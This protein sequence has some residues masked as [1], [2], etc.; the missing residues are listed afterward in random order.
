MSEKK[1]ILYYV[2]VAAIFIGLE[3]AALGMLHNSGTIQNLWIS[4]VS[5]SVMATVWGSGESVAEYFGLRKENQKLAEENFRLAQRV[6]MYENTYGTNVEN[7]ASDGVVGRFRYSPATIVK[8]S[9]RRQ[10]NYMI[11]DKGSD[12]GITPNSGVISSCGA[13]GIVDAVSRKYSYVLAFMNTGMN[14]SARVGREGAVGPLSW[15][16]TSMDGAILSEIPQ[17][18]PISEGDTVFTSG[19]SAIFPPDIPLGVTLSKT[20]VNGATYDIEV[21][22]FENYRKLRYVTVVE[23]IDRK[24]LEELEN[25]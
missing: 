14:V 22:L 20:L 25:R 3:I 21:R 18:I 12:D 4:N 8:M 11:L 6:R 5:H 2:S 13:L 17:H 24:E 23:N 19:S 10:H 7:E 16:G 9:T 1:N 15:D